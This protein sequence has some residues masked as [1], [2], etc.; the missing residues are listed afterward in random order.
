MD[1]KRCQLALSW[2]DGLAFST[3]NPRMTQSLTNC[4]RAVTGHAEMTAVPHLLEVLTS[5]PMSPPEEVGRLF[6]TSCLSES[7]PVC[8]LPSPDGAGQEALGRAGD[9]AEE[10][11]EN[12]QN[13]PVT[14][15]AS[16][17]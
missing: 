15:P 16:H 2:R 13:P 1:R 9:R 3:K 14:T 17:P 6:L 12:T 5:L 11:E 4:R 8:S 10:L 7:A